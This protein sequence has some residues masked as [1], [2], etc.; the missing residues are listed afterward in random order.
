LLLAKDFDVVHAFMLRIAPYVSDIRLP[1]ILEL[2]DSMQLNLQRRAERCGG[3]MKWVITE[4]LGRIS[5]LESEL[6]RDFDRLIVTSEKD[7]EFIA[8]D[9]VSVL[10]LGVDLETFRPP[11]VRGRRMSIVF[12]G[13]MGYAPN[14]DAACWFVDRCL[15]LVRVEIPDASLTIVGANP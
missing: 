7:R 5:R 12:S 1:K 11:S 15:P 13:N 6:H 2:N 9:N 10:P 3:V 4:E 8:G 14:I